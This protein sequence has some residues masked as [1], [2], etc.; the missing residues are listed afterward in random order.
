MVEANL[1][2]LHPQPP[3]IKVSGATGSVLVFGPGR[4]R[5]RQAP[6]CRGGRPPR[7]AAV[8]PCGWRYPACPLHKLCAVPSTSRLGR[9]AQLPELKLSLRWRW[10]KGPGRTAGEKSELGSIA[11]RRLPK[12]AQWPELFHDLSRQRMIQRSTIIQAT[13][14]YRIAWFGLRIRA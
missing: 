3:W 8:V 7:L 9:P 12:P 10:R 13:W 5:G 2:N 6:P 1:P 11:G 4:R 14:P